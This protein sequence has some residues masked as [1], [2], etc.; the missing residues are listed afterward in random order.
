MSRDPLLKVYGHIYPIDDALYADLYNACS[1]AMPDFDDVPVVEKDGDMA[2]ISMEGVYFPVEDAL[3][4]LQG[5]LKPAHKGK[6]DVIDLENWQLT[7]YV[8]SNGHMTHN[9]A[10]LNHILDYS[11]Q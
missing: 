8:F 3:A 7:R 9:S 4:V 11:G 10:S 2:R 1:T 5:H 6:L